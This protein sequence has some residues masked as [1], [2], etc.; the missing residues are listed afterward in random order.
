MLIKETRPKRRNYTVALISTDPNSYMSTMGSPWMAD[1]FVN[2]N[3]IMSLEEQA[4]P[5]FVHVTMQSQAGASIGTPTTTPP[6]L[7]FLDFQ[8]NTYPHLYTSYSI[9]PIG[10][11]KMIPDLSQTAPY[12]CYA[13]MKTN[14]N[15][16]IYIASMT[17]VNSISLRFLDILGGMYMPTVP[18]TMF[19]HFVPADF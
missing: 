6:V 12:P 10:M 8:N 2:M 16:E 5:Y 9:K 7:V 13:E 4:R 3:S 17:G 18:F 11:L 1:Y 15:E 14:D 19:I